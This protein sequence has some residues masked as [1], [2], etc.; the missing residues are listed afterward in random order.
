MAV[1]SKAYVGNLSISGNAGSNSADAIDIRLLCWLCVAL[2]GDSVRGGWLFRRIPD[3]CVFVCVC[4]CVCVWGRLCVSDCGWSRNL[5]ND[6][7]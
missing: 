7:A 5:N 1:K 3:V 6:T 4:V 2:V